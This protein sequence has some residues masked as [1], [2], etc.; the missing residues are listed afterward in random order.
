MFKC[1]VED[2]HG[3]RDRV[4]MPLIGHKLHLVED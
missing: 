1:H 2:E 3:I 4:L